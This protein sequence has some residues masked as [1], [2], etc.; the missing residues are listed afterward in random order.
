MTIHQPHGPD[1]DRPLAATVV[2]RRTLLKGAVVAAAVPAAVLGT[3]GPSA[4]A[5][6]KYATIGTGVD[7]VY[8]RIRDLSGSQYV[9]TRNYSF[10]YNPS[11]HDLCNAWANTY[12]SVLR[13][14]TAGATEVDW[15][16]CIGVYANK[17]GS[18]GTGDAFDLTYVRHTNGV[19]MDA[20]YS[21][22]SGA[23]IAHNRRYAGVAWATRKHLAE[24]GI[25]KSDPTHGNHIHAG[26]YK[27]GSSSLLLGKGTWDT[28]LVQ[29][30]CNAFTGAGIAFDGAWGNQTQG[31]Y[32]E[33]MR[34]LGIP[35]TGASSPFSSVTALQNMAH[36]LA[37]RGSVASALPA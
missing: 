21:H 20:N 8:T 18:H 34:R 33:M 30:A 19:Y 10:T 28:L 24:V 1:T 7:Q 13:W 36:A 29:Y 2:G 11:F 9:H 22:T 25:V 32:V 4:A 15:I 31:A 14:N 27:N 3:A 26:R 37:A 16:G 5:L 6:T 17:S 12:G 35:A 23:G